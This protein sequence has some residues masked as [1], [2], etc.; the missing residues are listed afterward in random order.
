MSFHV[1]RQD[2]HVLSHFGVVFVMFYQFAFGGFY[3]KDGFDT[4]EF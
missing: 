3:P 2:K 1:V 4:K